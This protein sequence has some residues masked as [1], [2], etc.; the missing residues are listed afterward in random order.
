M[1]QQPGFRFVDQAVGRCE[2][3][4]GAEFQRLG[5]LDVA[6]AQHQRQGGLRADEAGQALGAAGAGQQPDAGLG[7]AQLDVARVGGD[8]VVRREADLEAAAERGAV[9]GRGDRLAAGLERAQHPPSRAVSCCN[10]RVA[11]FSSDVRAWA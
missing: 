9:D 1:V 5:G 10:A 11:A 8:A 6:A 2:L 4:D 3:V 7:Q